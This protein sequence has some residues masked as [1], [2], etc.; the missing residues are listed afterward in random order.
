MRVWHY[1]TWEAFEDIGISMIINTTSL[2][3][4]FNEKP[5]VWFSTNPDWEET[6]RKVL[7]DRETGKET[8]GLSRDELWKVGINPVRIEVDPG[9]PFLSWQQLKRKVAYQK[10]WLRR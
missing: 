9:L 10:E 1:T 6:V 8:L 4:E 2:G 3:I 5:A 7:Q